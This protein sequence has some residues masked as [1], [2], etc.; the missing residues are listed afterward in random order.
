MGLPEIIWALGCVVLEM[1]TG[2]RV[3]SSRG[4]KKYSILS[5]IAESSPMS[6]VP[7]DVSD[8]W[9]RFSGEVFCSESGEEL[10]GRS[11]DSSSFR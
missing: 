5:V 11:V 4:T 9:E 2:K 6:E 1:M 3:W 7:A 10:F 8:E